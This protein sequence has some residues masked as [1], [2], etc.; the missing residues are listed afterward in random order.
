MPR[1][2]RISLIAPSVLFTILLLA[3]AVSSFTQIIDF[4]S[5]GLN[6]QA[7]TRGGLTMMYAR[8]PLS[9]RDYGVIQ[10]ALSN[11]SKRIWKINTADLVYEPEGGSPPIRASKEGEVIY[12]LYRHAGRNEVIKLQEAYEKAL[13]GNQEIRS[14]NGYEQRRLAAIA[15]GPKGIKAAA[16]AS[17][18]AFVSGE[19]ESGDSTDGAVFFEN[20]GQELPLGRLVAVVNGHVFEFHTR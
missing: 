18:I 17:A 19:L 9:V 2:R 10:L 20:A 12:D 1:S 11:G 3:S 13:F 6:Y 5:N 16:A 15:F 4:R 8:M 14:N 7:L